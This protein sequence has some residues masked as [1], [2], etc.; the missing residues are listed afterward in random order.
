[1]S[2]QLDVYVGVHKGQRGRF[3]DIMMKAGTMDYDDK[4]SVDRLYRELTAFKE[5]VFLHASLEERFIHPLL[6]ERVPGGARK[7]EE[8]HRMMHQQFDDI[9]AQLDGIRA[10]STES[11]MRGKLVLEFYRAWNRFTSFYF[12]HI[13]EEEEN[14]QPMLWKICTAKELD[15]AHKAMI[16][17]QNP[18]QLEYDI[19]IMLPAVNMHERREIFYAARVSMPPQ[20]FQGLLRVAEQVLSSRDWAAL[21]LEIGSD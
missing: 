11:E 15:Q 7:L 20:V 8:D 3:F 13:N 1:V 16:A 18:E 10:R 12:M 21:K 9:V 5:H 6:S 14:A 4:D 19:Q 17:S 2:D